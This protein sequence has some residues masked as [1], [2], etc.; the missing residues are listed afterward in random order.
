MW[1]CDK[2]G[3]EYERKDL[4]EL[5]GW[6]IWLCDGCIKR[7]MIYKPEENKCLLSDGKQSDGM[8]D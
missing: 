1:K 6:A 5:M 7:M 2:C 8:V 3:G 4:S